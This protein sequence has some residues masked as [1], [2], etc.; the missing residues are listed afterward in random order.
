M[1][2][3]V[4]TPSFI[5]KKAVKMTERKHNHYFKDVAN[6]QYV[7]VYRVLS[8]FNVTDPCL[9]HAIKKLLVAGG[10]GAGKD[11][12][13]DVKEAVDSLKRWEEMRGEDVVKSD[14]P[15]T[16]GMPVATPGGAGSVGGSS[17]QSTLRTAFDKLGDAP[18]PIPPVDQPYVD[19]EGGRVW[20]SDVQNGGKQMLDAVAKVFK[21]DIPRGMRN[22][23]ARELIL[24]EFVK[25]H[26]EHAK[27]VKS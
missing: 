26:A 6:L 22:E 5:P 20:S 13:Q 21:M 12:T 10:R 11:I 9:Q 4:A 16:Y 14:P 27:G 25:R 1:A 3:C 8:L 2:E 24:Q 18:A 17:G 15:A 7:D 23:L 19:T